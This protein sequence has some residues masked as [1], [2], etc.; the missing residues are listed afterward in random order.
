MATDRNNDLRIDIVQTA[1]TFASL[2][3]AWDALLDQAASNTYFLRWE[4]L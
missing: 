1:D 3:D 4:W 2:K